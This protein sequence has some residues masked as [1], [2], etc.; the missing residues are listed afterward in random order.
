M[1]NF[2]TVLFIIVYSLVA[3]DVVSSQTK[4]YY[5]GSGDLHST[6]N[7][8]TNP[9]ASGSNPVNFTTANQIFEIR[10]TTSVSTTGA[11]TV[12]GSNSKIVIGDPSVPAI[13][14]L[15]T[16]GFPITGTIDLA[17]SSL[18]SNAVTLEDFSLPTFGTCDV[19]STVIY[20][21]TSGSTNVGA[22][23]YG[24]LTLQGGGTKTLPNT[25][26][27][28]AGDLVYDNITL[29]S[30]G[31]YPYT[32]IRLGG[33]LT[34]IGTIV[35]PVATS[36][37]TLT[38]NGNKTQIILGNGNAARFFRLETQGTSSVEL[39]DAGGGTTLLVG[40]ASGGGIRLANGTTLNLNSNEMD[41]YQG[42]TRYNDLGTT[43]S[44]TGSVNAAISINSNV[45]GGIGTLYFTSGSEVL[46]QLQINIATGGS[47]SLGSNLTVADTL[48]LKSGSLNVGSLNTLSIDVGGT[49]YSTGGNL[50]SGTNGG[51]VNFNGNG[52]VSGTVSFNNVVMNTD[53]LE[54]GTSSTI[55][56]IFQ[57]NGGG[58][59][60]IHQPTYGWYS[61][62]KYATNYT[63]AGEWT[64]TWNTPWE[65][66]GYPRH[67]QVSNNST[68]HFT[69]GP[70]DSVWYAKGDFIIDAGSTVL[71]DNQYQQ[72]GLWFN[73]S[74]INNGT[75]TSPSGNM[76]TNIGFS[77]DWI[78]GASATS[79]LTGSFVRFTGNGDQSII[80]YTGNEDFGSI[81][82]QK[83]TGSVV[84]L[85]SNPATNITINSTEWNALWFMDGGSLDLNG[86]TMTFTENG[87]QIHVNNTV[88]SITGPPSSTL[89]F[90]GTKSVMTENGGSLSIGSNVTVKVN[91]NNI[92]FGGTA[93]TLNGTLE[94][95]GGSISVAPLYATGSTLKY[96]TTYARSAEWNTA[97]AG[98]PGYP[99]NV[100]ISN[101]STLNIA[102]LPG[103]TVWAAGGDLTIDFGSTVTIDNPDKPKG[104]T[105]EGSFINNGTF[106]P[107]G[108]G[109]YLDLSVGG[110][111]IKGVSA[112]SNLT[113]S[114]VHFYKP[115]TQTIKSYTGTETF[116]TLYL[117]KQSGGYV[118]LS[119]NPP[120]NVVIT[121][122]WWR[123]LW[124]WDGGTLDLNGQTLTFTGNGGEIHVN[125][126]V[127]SITGPAGSMLI[128]NGTKTVTTENGGSL[129]IGSNVTVKVPGQNVNFGGSATTI[130]GTLEINYGGWLSNPPT[131]AD[132]S[133]LRY[134]TGWYY[135]GG[136]GE[137]R[138]NATSG[139]GVPWNV[140]I[141][142]GTS[143][144]LGSDPNARTLKGN[145]LIDGGFTLSSSW[146]G[147]LNVG[148]NWTR[149][150]TGYFNCNVRC[151]FFNGN[152]TQT[153]TAYNGETFDR[154]WVSKFSGDLVLASDM[155][156]IGIAYLDGGKIRT[157]TNTF[158]IGSSA[159]VTDW[160]G[161]VIGN[162][163]KVF[164]TGAQSFT[165]DIGDDANYT[166]VNL[167]F[168]NVTT[169]G[170]LTA[171]T[172]NSEHPQIT[173]SGIDPLKS[174]NRFYRFT[175][176]G[177]I[178]NY[179]R[180]TFNFA[181]SDLD[182]GAHTNNFTVRRFNGVNWYT[183]SLGTRTA[184][185]IQMGRI[186]SFS[187]FAIGEPIQSSWTEQ[188]SGLS[189]TL[190]SISIVDGQ[191]AWACADGG[192]VVRTTN[193]GGTWQTVTS[194][195]LPD[196][197]NI[198]AVNANVALVCV[199]I[200]PT[201]NDGRIYRTTDAGVTWTIVYRNTGAGAF[202]DAVHMFD[203]LNGVA[204]GAPVGGNWVLLKTTDGGQS[205]STLTSLAQNGN[206]TGL[207]NSFEWVGTQLGWIGTDH[208]WIYRTTDGGNSW[209]AVPVKSPSWN[210]T[211]SFV[212]DSIGMA[213]GK[214][215]V[216]STTNSG[217]SWDSV[218]TVPGV[219][220]FVAGVD[221]PMEHWWLAQ[222][223]NVIQ[224]STNRGASWSITH[225]GP[226]NYTYIQMKK[227]LSANQIVGYAVGGKGMISQ[228]SEQYANS[229][230]A[231]SMGHGE[232]TPKDTVHVVIGDEQIFSFTPD[233][234]YHVDSVFVDGVYDTSKISYTFTNVISAHTI[235]V[236]FAINKHLINAIAGPHGSISPPGPQNVDHGSDITFTFLPDAKYR[237][238]SVFVD[239]FY[240][241]STV[242]YTFKNVTTT[243]NISVTYTLSEVS[244]TCFLK[245]R[246]NIVSLPIR[247]SDE[248]SSSIFPETGLPFYYYSG[249]YHAAD[250][251]RHGLGYW[252]RS[253]QADTTVYIG[254]P[255]L[256]DTIQ[257]KSGWNMI[258]SIT[259]PIAA[260]SII[261]DPPEIVTS[262][263]YN[264]N[265]IYM[266]KDTLNP[267]S[268]YWVKVSQSG[269]LILYSSSKRK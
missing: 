143:L 155:T 265:G 21:Q 244:S 144:N 78:K 54:F 133:T 129:Q 87:G 208:P 226:S 145:I 50:G 115:G 256:V 124:L 116:G 131:Y 172:V 150:S 165:Y 152:A 1:K 119:N 83:Q 49:I 26:F 74:I 210:L 240:D 72:K 269:K 92:D 168:T 25:T 216:N 229:I 17:A 181:N 218:K 14:L 84:R 77:G 23:T 58:V 236:K 203:D 241:T 32:A 86:Q 184:T 151:V 209:A 185:S 222:N 246:W 237:V 137:W 100:Q 146:G 6:L 261:S 35:N 153:L 163:K 262:S 110:D 27:T 67:I 105:I 103:D 253:P 4:Y 79:N 157:N 59:K 193:R 95:D 202:M 206:E 224:T 68:L 158:I 125:N 154:I 219:N 238:D 39:S 3:N 173:G 220:H 255:R 183:D 122:T 9:D 42:N 207:N 11:W 57:I 200:W 112:I 123:P 8:W 189:T 96:S 33:N 117:R 65:S 149:N 46:H 56:G 191:I 89:V 113:A 221:V 114:A 204:Y 111:W 132:G 245:E 81:W 76:A 251:L 13:S 85:S 19:T 109:M 136:N 30:G 98:T 268:G 31:S 62:L 242:S 247:L 199:N 104:L 121:D 266:A 2:F 212:N 82:L 230:I 5:G 106:T 211:V 182:P 175:N 80:A 178:F 250:T 198:C 147:D 43:G 252:V 130:Q 128:I 61:T 15:V 40:N 243:H 194:I 171:Q 188:A 73:G 53:S 12:S 260:A 127:R 118:Q 231:K 102:R 93:T 24:N 107:V 101:N 75:F 248:S 97:T 66:P 190:E 213:S 258:G 51:T 45:A 108:W 254:V 263:F 90:N 94:I 159:G 259:Y 257:V 141:A 225:L 223:N 28:V 205:W 233:E 234:N 264:Y 55:D 60:W 217:A 235:T 63:K 215:N 139:P 174:L 38:C 120:T 37:Y 18:G 160:S 267:W 70:T 34:Y 10:N 170:G 22:A 142:S 187:D 126:T 228:Y 192:A 177:L 91:G 29:G 169:S 71:L 44:I 64:S 196:P 239:E 48:F 69:P 148:G 134:N 214:N 140:H 197:Y 186:T 227:F 195:G 201:Y 166:P 47:I 88:R 164:A 180:S 232:I 161:W 20:N 179:C 135:T 167:N 176:S 138:S 156:V 52:T 16:S 41:S 249:M 99:W 162:F 7:W 36:S